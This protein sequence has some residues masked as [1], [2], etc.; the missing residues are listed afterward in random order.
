MIWKST[1]IYF[2]VLCDKEKAI[3]KNIFIA[4]CFE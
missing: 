4:F 2:I 1:L 3:C